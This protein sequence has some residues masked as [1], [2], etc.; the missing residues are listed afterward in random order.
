[1]KVDHTETKDPKQEHCFKTLLKNQHKFE[2]LVSRLKVIA[3]ERCEPMLENNERTFERLMENFNLMNKYIELITYI[4]ETKTINRKKLCIKFA[5]LDKN[6]LQKITKEKLCWKYIFIAAK[7]FDEILTNEFTSILESHFYYGETFFG[8]YFESRLI[9]AVN[10]NLFQIEIIDQINTVLPDCILNDEEEMLRLPEDHP[11]FQE[12]NKWIT[13]FIP[14]NSESMHYNYT[15]LGEK[16]KIM[17]VS[18][19]KAKGSMV[20]MALNFPYYFIFRNI[21][22]TEAN[23]FLSNP[24]CDTLFKVWNSSGVNFS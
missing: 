21:M 1:M 8:E 11:K 3:D 5:G 22:H 19:E 4:A 17:N 2:D 9:L 6:L 18:F 15:K 20:R 23:L 7:K 12:M 10:K 13:K 14:K 24:K 16:Y